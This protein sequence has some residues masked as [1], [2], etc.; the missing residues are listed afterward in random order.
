LIEKRPSVQFPLA[1]ELDT[2]TEKGTKLN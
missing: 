2:I 1:W